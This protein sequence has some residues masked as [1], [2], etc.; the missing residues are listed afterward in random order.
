MKDKDQLEEITGDGILESLIHEKNAE[1]ESLRAR[2]RARDKAIEQ[3]FSEENK[4]RLSNGEF[5]DCGADNR[6]YNGFWISKDQ[7][8]KTTKRD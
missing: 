7:A 4:R 6:F 5:L 8:E 2:L 3:I 1:I